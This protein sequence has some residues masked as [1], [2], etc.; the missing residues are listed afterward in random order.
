MIA[1]VSVDERPLWEIALRDREAYMRGEI[2]VPISTVRK[3]SDDAAAILQARLKEVY[4]YGALFTEIDAIRF[5]RSRRLMC[6]S[7]LRAIEREWLKSIFAGDRR[8]SRQR[9][10][11]PVELDEGL[12]EGMGGHRDPGGRWFVCKNCPDSWRKK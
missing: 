6:H 5:L 11:F 10:L 3:P 12:I 9:L 8:I 1:A 2:I 7:P 4:E